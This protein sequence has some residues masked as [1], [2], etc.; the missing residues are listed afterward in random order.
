M[1]P[2]KGDCDCCD[3]ISMLSVCIWIQ[4]PKASLPCSVTTVYNRAERNKKT[5]SSD[6]LFGKSE[7][8]VGFENMR[9]TKLPYRDIYLCRK[10]HL[11]KVPKYI[12][13]GYDTIKFLQFW[14]I[15]ISLLI[16]FK[17]VRFKVHVSRPNEFKLRN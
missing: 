7:E 11:T 6:Y 8:S 14:L 10:L 13:F 17:A 12:Y 1:K 4:K 3:C 2:F 9:H 16:Q 15:I 5:Y